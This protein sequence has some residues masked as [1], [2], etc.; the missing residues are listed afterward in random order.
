MTKKII[1]II[2]VLSLNITCIRPA[3]VYATAV[4]VD[5]A[6]ASELIMEILLLLGLAN[7]VTGGTIKNEVEG[8]LNVYSTSEVL[9]MMWYD[10]S[11]LI[12]SGT[13]EVG[14]G[15]TINIDL[16]KPTVIYDNVFKMDVVMDTY[17]NYFIMHPNLVNQIRSKGLMDKFI[18]SLEIFKTL[19]VNSLYEAKQRIDITFNNTNRIISQAVKTAIGNVTNIIVLAAQITQPVTYRDDEIL[20]ISSNKLTQ[21][22]R[23]SNTEMKEIYYYTGHYKYYMYFEYKLDDGNMYYRMVRSKSPIIYKEGTGYEFSTDGSL[24]N[25]RYD[26][27][28]KELK[29][30]P[31]NTFS[32]KKFENIYYCDSATLEEFKKAGLSTKY[33]S[34][35]FPYTLNEA[36]QLINYT[37]KNVINNYDNLS[38]GI[39][40]PIA[41]NFVNTVTILGGAMA[42]DL[43]NNK[44]ITFENA[45]S[46]LSSALNIAIG[47]QI[48]TNPVINDNVDL[49]NV[50]TSLSDIALLLYQIS[51]DV[52]NI[53]SQAGTGV[54][55]MVEGIVAGFKTTLNSYI[56]DVEGNSVILDIPGTLNDIYGE[57]AGTGS[58]VG[59]LVGGLTDVQTQVKSIANQATKSLALEDE[60]A[61]GIPNGSKNIFQAITMLI[62]I[63]ILLLY[64]FLRVLQFIVLLFKVPASTT[65]FPSQLITGL[66]YLKTRKLIGHKDVI[67]SFEP[68]KAVDSIG[69]DITIWNFFM[70]LI[71][72]I[73]LFNIIKQ[74]RRHV[75][76]INM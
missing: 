51:T 18:E 43:V 15:I 22:F 41:K 31:I 19:G 52:I 64:L 3:S 46:E 21:F 39:V 47:A 36:D 68:L 10:V 53:Y 20:D 4:G 38:Q 56:T 71:Y 61:T 60:L 40:N 9:K 6:T 14:P 29:N 30:T 8:D 27:Y 75:D 25:F 70:G 45:D 33:S 50:E 26:T 67:L 59:D 34:T 69:F 24:V 1:A 76:K 55:S 5:A 13:L 62:V 7:D 57:L 11:D 16:G 32:I 12:E 2:L 17:G 72:I 28:N 48:A 42:N 65:L 74:L 23:Y 54:N 49:T 73:I 63:L 37:G 44:A 58:L 66:D 35:Y